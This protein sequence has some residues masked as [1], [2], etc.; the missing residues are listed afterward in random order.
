[1]QPSCLAWIECLLRSLFSIEACFWTYTVV[2]YSRLS[3]FVP[4]LRVAHGRAVGTGRQEDHDEDKTLPDEETTTERLLRY[5][6]FIHS[7]FYLLYKAAASLC[8]CVGVCLSVPPLFSD[9]TVGSRPNCAPKKIAPPSGG[10]PRGVLWGGMDGQV[11]DKFY[12]MPIME[13][14]FMA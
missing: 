13:W 1:M 3:Q 11:K 4:A 2:L 10:G 8:V 7:R 9:T 5:G 12:V 14:V 6:S